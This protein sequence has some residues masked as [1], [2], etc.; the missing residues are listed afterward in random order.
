MLVVA[1]GALPPIVYLKAS[2]QK[3]LTEDAAADVAQRVQYMAHA[4]ASLPHETRINEVRK[5]ALTTRERLTYID[6]SGRVVF[7]STVYDI[8]VLPDHSKRSEVQRALGTRF[9]REPFDPQVPGVGVAR[10]KSESTGEDTLYAA[11]RVDERVEGPSDVLRLAIPAAHV[12]RLSSDLLTVFRNSQ[13]VAVSVALLLSLLAAIAFLRPLQRVVAA[14]QALA[15]G[16]F[17]ISV[18][19]LGNDEVG[20]AGRAL[21]T[22]GEQLRRRLAGAQSGEGLLVQ[23]VQ[24]LGTPLAVLGPDGRVIAINGPAR[25]VLHSYGMTS[26]KHLT[27]LVHSQSYI[28]AM[29]EA[30]KRC[31]PVALRIEVGKSADNASASVSQ[32]QTDGSRGRLTTIGWIHV[33]KLPDQPPLGVF[34]GVQALGRSLSL[35]PAPENVSAVLVEDV[36]RQAIERA[37]PFLRQAKLTV[38][39]IPGGGDVRVAEVDKRLTLAVALAVEG[40]I[41]SFGGQEATIGM[42]LKDEPSRIGV[43]LRATVTSDTQ[44][45]ARVLLEPLGGELQVSTSDCCL[46]LP[47]A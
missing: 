39:D 41:P 6:A 34:L 1:A 15:S 36:L 2:F 32:N 37:A 35:L 29:H 11:A 42:T 31:E 5:A 20:D 43:V 17:T 24:M 44:E 4:L 23:F 45:I 21:Q 12:E 9:D 38:R 8:S 47:K 46:W 26:E 3:R 19:G 25:D 22:L 18:K 14:A 40:T 30:E 16:D 13:A 33:L 7:D 27:D 10:R 28:T